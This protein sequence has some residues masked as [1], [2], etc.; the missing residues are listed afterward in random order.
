MVAF[1]PV[2][3]N[4]VV[5]PMSDVPAAFWY[6]LAVAAVAGARPRPVLAGVAFG[7]AVWTRPLAAV[8][9]PALLLAMPRD[10]RVLARV[11]LGGLPLAVAMALTQWHLYGSPLRT[12]YGGTDGLFT[13][14]NVGRHLGAFLRWTIAAHSPLLVAA[15]A[16]GV[17]RGAGRLAWASVAGLL[18][19][20]IPYLFNLQFFDDF[21]LLRYLLPALVP[22]LIVATL[23]TAALVSRAIPQRV[24]GLAMLLLAA[25]VAAASFAF[26]TGTFT[27]HLRQQE[28]RYV[29]VAAWVRS[30]T[31]ANAVMLAEL[32]SGTL[33]LYA[34]RVTLRW[35][36]IPA[37]RLA[38]TVETL[39][40]RGVPCYAAAD[41]EVEVRGL[42]RRVAT[43]ESGLVAEPIA[44][45]RSV[46]VYRVSRGW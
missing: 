23:G 39:Q 44:R 22:C 13:T 45:V 46:V 27:F 18:L 16:A 43:D 5:Q 25:A 20:V 19:G 14:V 17:W 33:R 4:M 11:M 3:T 31:P 7:M 6:L 36:F 41:G 37:G 24:R 15:L 40:S 32:H 10:R 1:N 2:V 8:L 38:S 35:K 9:F 21:D 42:E 34:D 28:S 12:G 29:D 30:H 26:T